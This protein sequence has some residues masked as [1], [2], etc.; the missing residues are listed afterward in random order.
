MRFTVCS[1]PFLLKFRTCDK[2]SLSIKV[3][4]NC[5]PPLHSSTEK[6]L[7]SLQIQHNVYLLI[8]NPCVN[9]KFSCKLLHNATRHFVKAIWT[10]HP[11]FS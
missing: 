6:A 9:C 3:K 8:N 10:F 1:L 7:Q 4:Y 11:S 2:N 5:P